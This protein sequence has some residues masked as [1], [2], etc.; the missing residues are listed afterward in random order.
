ML[1][2]RDGENS[3][4]FCDCAC[5]NGALLG[6][7]S[8]GPCH[9]PRPAFQIKISFR[10]RAI[11]SKPVDATSN[12]CSRVLIDVAPSDYILW[13]GSFRLIAAWTACGQQDPVAESQIRLALPPFSP[14]PF[15]AVTCLS[16]A[17]LSGTAGSFVLDLE[18]RRP[19]F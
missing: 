18:S 9:D 2:L 6:Q 3:P 12:P 19:F 15:F 16:F 10:V 13:M 7:F 11:A 17:V 1:R 5:W 14:V 4:I 8:T